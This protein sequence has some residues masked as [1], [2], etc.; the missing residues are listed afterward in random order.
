MSSLPDRMDAFG[1]RHPLL[2]LLAILCL[3][4]VVTIVLL[5]QFQAPAVV[6]E[7]F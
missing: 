4:V 7:F 2:M 5:F 3:T 6:Y 1:R